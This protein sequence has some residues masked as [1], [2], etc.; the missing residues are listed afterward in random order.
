MQPCGPEVAR[1][2][3]TSEVGVLPDICHRLLVISPSRKSIFSAPVGAGNATGGGL[4]NQTNRDNQTVTDEIYRHDQNPAINQGSNHDV[5]Q[6]VPDKPADKPFT[7]IE[8]V[9]AKTADSLG[10]NSAESE[11]ILK[12]RIDGSPSRNQSHDDNNGTDIARAAG[13]QI[14]LQLLLAMCVSSFLVR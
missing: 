8:N 6:Q 7:H 14:L 2:M 10:T 4:S 1:A 3:A 5:G 13:F 9:T 12:Q 11:Q